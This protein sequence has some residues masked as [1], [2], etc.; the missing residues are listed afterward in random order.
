MVCLGLAAPC[1]WLCHHGVVLVALRSVPVSS[2]GAACAAPGL[3]VGVGIAISGLGVVVLAA[4]F[5]CVIAAPA[6]SIVGNP[7][8][9]RRSRRLPRSYCRNSKARAVNV[10]LAASSD[11]TIAHFCLETAPLLMPLYRATFDIVNLCNNKISRIPHIPT[12]HVTTALAHPSLSPLSRRTRI[13]SWLAP[14]PHSQAARNRAP[15]T[16]RAPGS[17]PRK[18]RGWYA[19]SRATATRR[20][21]WHGG[22]GWAH[23]VGERSGK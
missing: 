3:L 13:H 7:T 17:R 16:S 20:R 6:S 1:R 9:W 18:R 23:L 15:R 10:S 5:A 21:G 14:P 8:L 12:E 4:M 22:T 11:E 19:P 2:V